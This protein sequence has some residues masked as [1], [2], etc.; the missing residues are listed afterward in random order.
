MLLE[1]LQRAL[2]RQ[3][4]RFRV[5]ARSIVAVEA[6]SRVVPEDRHLGVRRLY[7]VD[8]FLRN[9]SAV[10][11]DRCVDAQARGRQPGNAAAEAVANQPDF[12]PRLPARVLE[13][14]G[15]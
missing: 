14:S 11:T 1:K 6:V 9:M 5:V 2:P 4:C 13:R 7:R 12:L 8:A 15:G 3:F 10:V